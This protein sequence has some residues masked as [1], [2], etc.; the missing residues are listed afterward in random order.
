MRII[1]T[2]GSSLQRISELSQRKAF[3]LWGRIDPVEHAKR[4]KYQPPA[5]RVRGVC[6]TKN[7]LSDYNRGVQATMIKK[8]K[9]IS[10]R[11][12]LIRLHIQSGCASIISSSHLSID[13][14]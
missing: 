6:Y 3:L 11:R 14:K 7:H 4:A 12:K 5:M 10:W 13:E 8:G 1:P 9:V 2:Q